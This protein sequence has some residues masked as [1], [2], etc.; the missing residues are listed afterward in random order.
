[1]FFTAKQKEFYSKLHVI[2]GDVMKS[3]LHW[4][5][6]SEEEISFYYVFHTLIISLAM[7]ERSI[8]FWNVCVQTGIKNKTVI[9]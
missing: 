1:M 2:K 9:I 3:Y 4:Q 8:I 7:Q 5:E 6:N